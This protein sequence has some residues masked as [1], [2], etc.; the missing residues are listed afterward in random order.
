M[1]AHCRMGKVRTGFIPLDLF[2]MASLREPSE[3]LDLKSATA[4]NST[5]S[6]VSAPRHIL[7][8]NLP[9]AVKHL[10]DQELEQLL[11]AI[12]AERLQRG[13]KSPI[14]AGTTS[15]R[16]AKAATVSLSPGKLNAVRA[17]L[18]AGVRPSK[19][20]KQF[21]IPVRDVQKALSKS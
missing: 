7:P 9:T 11:A 15:K 21:G 5:A 12:T 14:P 2:S 18:K 17:A 10:N 8:N 6:T 19:I 1:A 3:P 20:A 13:T 16:P 4:S